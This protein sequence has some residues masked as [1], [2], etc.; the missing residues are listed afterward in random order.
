MRDWSIDYISLALVLVA[1]GCF[2]VIL[3]PTSPQDNAAAFT[4]LGAVLQAIVH[5]PPLNHSSDSNSSSS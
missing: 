5:R 4:L 1:A 3:A 2:W